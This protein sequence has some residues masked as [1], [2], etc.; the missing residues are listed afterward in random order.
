MH[1]IRLY[2]LVHLSSDMTRTIKGLSVNVNR[3]IN[4]LNYTNTNSNMN[5]LNL[6]KDKVNLK[7]TVFNL[8][9]PFVS[10]HPHTIAGVPVN[11]NS[12][13]TNNK[14]YLKD[15]ISNLSVPFGSFYLQT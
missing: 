13:K 14:V 11:V 5:S 1:L 3:D 7:D 4:S 9:V 6:I 8:T 15:T 2:L 10:F 12:D